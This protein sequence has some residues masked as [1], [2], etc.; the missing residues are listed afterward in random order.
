MSGYAKEWR[1]CGL[2]AAEDIHR[3]KDDLELHLYVL[4][5]CGGGSSS[6]SESRQAKWNWPGTA[7]ACW[8]CEAPVNHEVC[9]SIVAGM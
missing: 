6:P 9:S 7:S 3:R 2:V 8:E 1:V 5:V 4:C